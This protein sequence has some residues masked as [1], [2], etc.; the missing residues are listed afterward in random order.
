MT[1]SISLRGVGRRFL[2]RGTTVEAVASV[3]LDIAPGEFVV[4]V[5]PSG[6]GKSTVL[7]MVAGLF[8]P[9]S[10]EVLVDGRRVTGVD[11]K[12]GYVTQQDNL[13][14]WRTLVQNVELPLELAVRRLT[15][16]QRRAKAMELIERVGLKGFEHHYPH[17]LSGGMRQRI[18]I[19]RT[20][21]YNPQII[22]MDEPFGPLDAMT[23]GV[24][25]QELL[26][27]WSEHRKTVLFITHDLMEAIALGDRVVVMSARPGR[28]KA[29]EAV[30]IPR[31]RKLSEVTKDPRFHRIHD[32][33]SD[34]IWEELQQQVAGGGHG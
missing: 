3:D 7:N 17:E 27:L 29:V 32:R 18:N 9:T 6:C 20:L 23:R 15:V 13:L 30:D 24:L 31:P 34:L 12:V 26:N 19:I 33:L 14:P 21:S 28:V 4:I 25:Q 22:L 1:P 11:A 10:G 2:S 16:P 8:E 5:G